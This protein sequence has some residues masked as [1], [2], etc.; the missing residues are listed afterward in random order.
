[1][2]TDSRWQILHLENLFK[3]LLNFETRIYLQKVDTIL[4]IIDTNF[5]SNNSIPLHAWTVGLN[6]GWI[7][8]N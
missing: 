6:L 1:M 8:V 3:Y 2:V 4:F 5:I 7:Y